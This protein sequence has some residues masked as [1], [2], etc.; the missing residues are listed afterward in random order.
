MKSKTI[1]GQNFAKFFEQ[2]LIRGSCLFHFDSISNN[3]FRLEAHLFPSV[4]DPIDAGINQRFER[5]VH[6]PISSICFHSKLRLS[7]NLK[8]LMD[9]MSCWNLMGGFEVKMNMPYFLV[10]LL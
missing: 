8:V 1:F 7:E 2:T 10:K 9:L 3:G 6:F 5:I 4:F